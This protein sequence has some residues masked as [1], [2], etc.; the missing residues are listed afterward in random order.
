[1]T[2]TTTFLVFG[3]AFLVLAGLVLARV[4]YRTFWIPAS[5]MKP[6]LLPGASLVA[7]AWSDGPIERGDVVVFERN[8]ANF[9]KRI[10]GM[11]S[12]K[13][14]LVDGRVLIDGT[15]VP[16]MP[17]G[18]F[19]EAYER[20][21][22]SGV[23]PVCRNNVAPGGTCLKTMLTET[24]PEGR[25]YNVLDV[26]ARPLDDTLVFHVPPGHYF[27]LG[28]NRDNSIDSR[29][30]TPPMGWGFVPAEAIFAK[31]STVL[32]SSSGDLADPSAWREGRYF[33]RVR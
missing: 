15:A 32:F 14:Q 29:V 1:M 28:D 30:T 17:A 20:S 13:I 3:L 31:A 19:E 24:L 12:E 9:V 4:T 8:G 23:L 26:G 2:R 27:V 11:P 10:I 6:T 16:Q 5:S 33:V 22:P 18:D 7:R 25:S 21:G